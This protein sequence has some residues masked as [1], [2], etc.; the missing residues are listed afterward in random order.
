MGVLL[1]QYGLG[2]QKGKLS[3]INFKWSKFQEFYN[4]YQNVPLFEILTSLEKI[5]I[6]SKSFVIKPMPLGRT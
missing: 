2:I 4:W 6:S 3:N 1:S 5:Q